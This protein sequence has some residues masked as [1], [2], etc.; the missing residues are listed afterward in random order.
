MDILHIK[1]EKGA[2]FKILGGTALSQAGVMTIGPGE[3]SGKEER[4]EG[5]QIIYIIE[6]EADVRLE[7]E[8]ETLQEGDALIIPAG[9]EHHIYNRGMETV[10]IFTVYA[11]PSY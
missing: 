5:D 7:E 1:K 2:E 9:A 6:G 3:D 10:C 4:H 8:E 11:P